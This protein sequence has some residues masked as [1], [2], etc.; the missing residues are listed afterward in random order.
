MLSFDCGHTS[1]S[2]EDWY[3]LIHQKGGKDGDP[4]SVSKE[5]SNA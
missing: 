1:V 5:L 4:K 2:H 3:D